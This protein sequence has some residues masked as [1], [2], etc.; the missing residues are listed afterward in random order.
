MLHTPVARIEFLISSPQSLSSRIFLK[1]LVHHDELASPVWRENMLLV[2]V[3][4][5]P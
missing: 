5:T 1:M 4:L 3:W 2:M